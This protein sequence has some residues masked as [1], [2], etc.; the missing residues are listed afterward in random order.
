MIRRDLILDAFPA[1]DPARL[2]QL[3]ALYHGFV[4]WNARINLVSRSDLENLYERHILHSLA[5]AFYMDFKPLT[6]VM[7]LGTGGGFPGLP[8]AIW[9]P[10]ARFTLVDSIAK[11]IRVV[12]ALVKHTELQNVRV[13]NSR[14][15]AVPGPFDFVVTRAV[16]PAADLVRWVS[17]K[18]ARH[19]SHDF[20][21]GI[22][23]WKGGDLSTELAAVAR[24]KPRVFPLREHLGQDFFATKQLVFIPMS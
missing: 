17:G 2:D 10:E 5:L 6:E 16:A 8:L 18:F 22:W 4:E 19:Y 23:M 3:E 15:E 21:N 14:A 24:H 11:K 7:D 12:E 13:L 1:A 9:Y 20:R